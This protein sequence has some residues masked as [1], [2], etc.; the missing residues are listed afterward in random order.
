MDDSIDPILPDFLQA[1]EHSVE[2]IDRLRT[3]LGQF[4]DASQQGRPM[5]PE[6][7]AEY[8]RQLANV[9]RDATR[10]RELLAVWWQMVGAGQ[11]H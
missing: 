10:L 6:V 7:V 2:A 11:A 9:D 8:A 4:T 3:V 1:F 5:R